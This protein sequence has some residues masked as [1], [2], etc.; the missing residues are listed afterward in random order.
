MSGVLFPFFVFSFGA[1]NL[2]ATTNH[3]H[4]ERRKA[5]KITHI[6]SYDNSCGIRNGLVINWATQP[7]ASNAK[8]LQNLASNAIVTQIEMVMCI[9]YAF[10][11]LH[12]LQGTNTKKN[13]RHYT[14]CI[15]FRYGGDV[16]TE[17]CKFRDKNR[18][19]FNAM[20]AT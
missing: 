12:S 1:L 18:S 13:P 5:T 20:Q 6:N 10:W 7:A 3:H 15:V 17:R 8:H 11:V 16:T 9:H 4:N 14:N 19:S 2:H